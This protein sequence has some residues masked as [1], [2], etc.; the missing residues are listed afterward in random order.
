MIS[1][2]KYVVPVLLKD[3]NYFKSANVKISD[4]SINLRFIYPKENKTRTVVSMSLK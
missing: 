2:V 1:K 4:N 3:I